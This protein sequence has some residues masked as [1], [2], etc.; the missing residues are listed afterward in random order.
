MSWCVAVINAEEIKLKVATG[1][2]GQLIAALKDDKV[3][4]VMFEQRSS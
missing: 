2:T 4:V 3:D 1:G